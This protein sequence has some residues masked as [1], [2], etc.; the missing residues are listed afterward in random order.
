MHVE[1]YGPSLQSRGMLLHSIATTQST[2]DCSCFFN[3]SLFELCYSSLLDGMLYGSTIHVLALINLKVQFSR[4][5]RKLL[6]SILFISTFLLLHLPPFDL[7]F[8]CLNVFVQE[9]STTSCRPRV[10][11][12][13][14]G[15]NHLFG[16]GSSPHDSLSKSTVDKECRQRLQRLLDNPMMQQNDSSWTR[17]CQWVYIKSCIKALGGGS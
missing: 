13:K 16:L 14:A 6:K 11:L 10:L 4:C 1:D 8:Y 7:M 17:Q 5:S 9:P 2:M 15:R 12:R 3:L